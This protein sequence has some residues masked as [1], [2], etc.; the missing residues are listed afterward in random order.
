MEPGGHSPDF[1]SV[2]DMVDFTFVGHNTVVVRSATT[3]IMVDPLLFP[4]GSRFPASYQPL[5]VR[6]LEP[7][8][9]V[10]I[11]HSHPDHF[12]PASLLQFP[13]ETR[14]IVPSIERENLLSVAMGLRLRELGF[15]NI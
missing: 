14:I 12:D 11:T 6:H 1:D 8:H 3:R 9:A 7:I 15:H 5:Q 4:T 13:P 10:L 2:Q